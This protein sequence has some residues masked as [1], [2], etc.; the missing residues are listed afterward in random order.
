MTYSCGDSPTVLLTDKKDSANQ[1]AICDKH[2]TDPDFAEGF[3]VKK[4]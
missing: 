4:L 1:W 2:K 3:E